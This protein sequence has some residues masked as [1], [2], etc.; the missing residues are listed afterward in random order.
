[1]RVYENIPEIVDQLIETQVRTRQKS[2]VQYH[3]EPSIYV[4]KNPIHL[5]TFH[6]TS[7]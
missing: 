7:E 6:V 1:M 5:T 3:L 4:A 2:I